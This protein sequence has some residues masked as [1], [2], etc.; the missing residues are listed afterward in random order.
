MS[1]FAFL[2]YDDRTGNRTL[3]PFGGVLAVRGRQMTAARSREKQRILMIGH[4]TPLLEGVYDLLQVVGYPVDISPSWAETQTAEYDSPPSLVILDL[5]S[6]SPDVSHVAEQIHSAP[7]W[8]K[9]PILFISFSGDDRI[10][11][12][13]RRAGQDNGGPVHFYA[14]TLLGME[15]LLDQVETCLL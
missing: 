5:S 7:A 15:E 4:N 9:V 3:N 1:F 12:L 6:A 8:S 2:C 11:E 10:R 13:K 14:H